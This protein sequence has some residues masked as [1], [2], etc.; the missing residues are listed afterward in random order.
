[1]HSTLRESQ[2]GTMKLEDSAFQGIQEKRAEVVM[3]M[4]LGWRNERREISG[5]GCVSV[6]VVL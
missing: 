6:S 1:M 5:E 2:E 3:S 4:F